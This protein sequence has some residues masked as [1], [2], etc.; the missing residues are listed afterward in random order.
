[1]PTTPKFYK[2]LDF[3]NF[4]IKI[5]YYKKIKNYKMS[6]NL[7][8]KNRIALVTGATGGIGNA[9][10]TEF[11]NQGARVV[12][13]GRNIEKLNIIHDK[14]V[15]SNP[16]APEPVCIP[17]DL[18][19]IDAEPTLIQRI[20]DTCGKLDIL[21]NNAGIIE[22]CMFLKSGEQFTSKMMH[23]NFTVPYNL[24][25]AAIPH[26]VSN[27]YGRIISITSIAGFMGDAG[28]SAYAASKGALASATKSIATE[29][30]RRGITANCIAP[31]IIETEATKKI[32]PKHRENMRNQ[33]PSRRLGK[34]EEVAYLVAFLASEYAAYINGQQIHINGGLIR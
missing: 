17:L 15:A 21:V 11:F 27:K 4:C 12:L 20:I 10:A 8:L 23:V 34:P 14:L 24:S 30:G 6:M 18:T 9:I 19:A 26:M 28:M 29:Y 33:I 25:R 7:N 2:K 5:L 31:G 13:T 1:M 3:F 32:D 16:K 22:G